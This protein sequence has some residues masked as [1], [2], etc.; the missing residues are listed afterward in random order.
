ML[1]IRQST[2]DT[3]LAG[4]SIPRGQLVCAYVASANHD[5]RRYNNPEAFDIRRTPIPHVAFGS[6]P[7]TCLGMHLSR[8]ETRIVLDAILERLPCLRLDPEGPFPRIRG[9]LAFRS[10]DAIPVCF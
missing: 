3:S 10:P 9:N 1:V 6:G 7:H 4:V 2:R 8:L 5:E